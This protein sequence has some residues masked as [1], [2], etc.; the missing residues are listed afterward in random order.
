MSLIIIGNLYFIYFYL[1]EYLRNVQMKKQIVYAGIYF[2]TLSIYFLLFYRFGKGIDFLFSVTVA[3]MLLLIMCIDLIEML[4]PDHLVLC[5]IGITVL[6][7]IA[8]YI[9]KDI[10]PDILFHFSGALL[11]GLI[12]FIILILSKGGIGQGDVT[13]ISAIG[14][15]LGPY[16]VLVNIIL[17][18]FLGSIISIFLLLTKM[19]NRKDPIPFGPFIILAFFITQ[20]YGPKIL[21]WYVNLLTL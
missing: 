16:Y 8:N 19:K 12:F 15:I 9:I 10:K 17:S 13:L 4:I 1:K 5:T 20:L 14:F 11:A 18:F 3:S 6:Y 21:N 2:I 7:H